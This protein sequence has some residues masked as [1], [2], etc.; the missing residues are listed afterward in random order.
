LVTGSALTLGY[1]YYYPPNRRF[2]YDVG[3]QIAR[4]PS[5]V[6]ARFQF[7]SNARTEFLRELD[8]QDPYVRRLRC[9]L[10]NQPDVPLDP[11]AQIGGCNEFN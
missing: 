7:P 6:S 3:L 11:S 10:Q 9:E 1:D 5:A 4:R 8:P 2:G